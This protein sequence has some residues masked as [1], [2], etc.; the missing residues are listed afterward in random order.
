M[1]LF[2]PVVEAAISGQQL[3]L[4]LCGEWSTPQASGDDDPNDPL[5]NP[6]VSPFSLWKSPADVL[7]SGNPSCSPLAIPQLL[8]VHPQWDKPRTTMANNFC[9]STIH[10]Q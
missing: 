2:I 7:S 8:D 9:S 4:L 3:A 10:Q 6:P 1:L 5:V